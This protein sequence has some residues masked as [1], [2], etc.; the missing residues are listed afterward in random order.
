MISTMPG[1]TSTTPASTGRV[2][3]SESRQSEIRQSE[4]RQSE[5]HSNTSHIR[6]P[7]FT[8]IELLVALPMAA[9]LAACA[10]NLLLVQ[11]RLATAAEARSH[12]ARELRYARV[13][14]ENEIAPL[15]SSDIITATDT[16]IEFDAQLGLALL[17]ELVNSQ[18]II[19]APAPA[20]VAAGNDDAWIGTV[21]AGDDITT[22]TWPANLSKAP[23]RTTATITS[24][25][26]ALGPGPCG[27]AIATGR[28]KLSINAMPP[29]IL[30]N[31]APLRFQRRSAYTHYRSG[32]SWWLGRKSRSTS[33]WD[34]VQPVAGPLLSH[35]A[36]GMLVQALTTLGDSTHTT[37][38][39]T[40]SALRLELRAPRTATLNNTHQVDSL[41]FE[42]ALR[43][44]TTHYH[45][46]S[47]FHPTG[48]Q[49]LALSTQPA[50]GSNTGRIP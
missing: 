8:L 46:L 44:T 43:G 41:R 6:R 12:T 3:H 1:R 9:L 17:C 48:P 20:Q 7:G 5:S 18:T 15:S 45:S 38:E 13:M 39:S 25:P 28:W 26:N 10:I 34:V 33:G 22:W 40:T 11:T 4:I 49:I 29:Q 19:V 36:G 16:L 14:L 24:N 42:I 35:A 21:R 47:T 2:D 31:Q 50:A 27:A 37:A 32:S 23:E 30:L